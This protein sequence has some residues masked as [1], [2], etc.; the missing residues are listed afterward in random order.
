[1]TVPVTTPSSS[2]I[3]SIVPP[4]ALVLG[5]LLRQ[6]Q[7]TLL[8]LLLEDESL[9]GVTHGDDLARVHVVLDGELPGR[10]DA[11]RLVTDVE[12]DLVAVDL[13]DRA[14]HDVTIVEVLDG[15]VDGGKEVLLGADVVDG[16]LR[17][18]GLRGGDG[19]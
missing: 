4:G 8:V 19:H 1:M 3:F 13:D 18:G 15:G 2:L 7:A 10:D 6:D 9:D 16:N 12:E 11:L 5:A 14:F 17:G